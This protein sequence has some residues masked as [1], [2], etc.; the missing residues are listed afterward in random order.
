MNDRPKPV[1]PGGL[2]GGEEEGLGAN[3]EIGIK[4]RALYGSVEEEGIP[5][6]LMDLLDKLD[7]AEKAAAAEPG[8]D[9]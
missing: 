6:R 7:R 9:R 3:S 4:L 1:R 5:D 8:G 2:F